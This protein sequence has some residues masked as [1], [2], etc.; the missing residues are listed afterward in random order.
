MVQGFCAAVGLG[1]DEIAMV[2][3]APHDLIMGRAAGVAMN[4]G[5]LSG[6]SRRQ[7]LAALADLV[8]DSINDLPARP[9][10]RLAGRR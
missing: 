4:V 7:D 10:F 6:T 8:V 1:R 3:D 5:V 2:G 9:E